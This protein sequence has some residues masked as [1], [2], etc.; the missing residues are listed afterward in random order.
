[1]APH[2][3]PNT[4]IA[5]VHI[6]GLDLI[7][8]REVFPPHQ[9]LA[10][11]W[12]AQK[13]ASLVGTKKFLEI[14]TGTG[15]TALTCAKQGS[16][17]VATDVSLEAVKN[18]KI[19]AL[20]NDLKIDVRTSDVFSAVKKSEKFDV[21]FWNHPFDSSPRNISGDLEKAIY[22]PAYVATQNYIREGMKHLRKGGRL[23]LG[24]GMSANFS[25]LKQISAQN[26]LEMKEL[27]RET[28]PPR[29]K[30]KVPFD[31]FIFE[32]VRKS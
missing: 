22:D 13:V 3:K 17:V 24:T 4:N 23:L 11:R 10:S 9:F 14:G 8:L 20:L 29:N 31:V 12:M 15:I 26:T 30:I 25:L 28:L 19:N 1:M 6:D 2:I 32:F 7:V 21:I 27:F 5:V 16:N 18:A